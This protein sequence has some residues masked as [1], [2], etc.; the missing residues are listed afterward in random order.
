M[1]TF[2]LFTKSNDLVTKIDAADKSQAAEF[3]AQIKDLSIDNLHKVFIIKE[4]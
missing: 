3:F 1:K 2:G 4:L